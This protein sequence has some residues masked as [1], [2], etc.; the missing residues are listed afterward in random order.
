[1]IIN[2]SKVLSLSHLEQLIVDM[3]D[4]SKKSLRELF[5]KEMED[6]IE[7]INKKIGYFQSIAPTL[8]K[9]LYTANTM[10]GITT[11]QSDQM[12][13][14]YSDVLTRIREGAF[15]TAYYRLSQKSPEGFVTQ[16]LIDAWKFKILNYLQG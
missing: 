14:D 12:F 9:E 3:D 15:P 13:D 16:E 8:L 10:A 4:N 6:L 2:G 11:P 1:M 5:T 7:N